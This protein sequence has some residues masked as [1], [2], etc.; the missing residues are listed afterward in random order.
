MKKYIVW[1][2]P[3]GIEIRKYFKFDEKPEKPGDFIISDHE[4]NASV[5]NRKDRDTVIDRLKKIELKPFGKMH[6]GY[7]RA[8]KR[9]QRKAA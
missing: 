8:P 2:R 9:K 3:E 7:K 6:V 5:L 1:L 4:E